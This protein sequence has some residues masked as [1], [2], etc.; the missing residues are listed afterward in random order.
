MKK[1]ILLILF[2]VLVLS[3][4]SR[5]SESES[6]TKEKDFDGS[7]YN[8]IGDGTFYLINESGTTEN[9]NIIVIYADKDTVMTQIGADTLG[10][11]GSLLSYI[12]ID[13]ME[14]SKEQLADSQTSITLEKDALAV[15]VHVVEC[16]QYENNDTDGSVITYKSG[17]Y[18]VIE[19]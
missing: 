15:G 17:S 18:E 19:K 13:G 1:T 7:S 14:T 12:Y 2:L 5:S 16:V 3:A 11:D 8:E 4:C 10:F 9:G 6:S